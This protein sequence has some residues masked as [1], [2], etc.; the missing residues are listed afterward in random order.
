[1]SRLYFSTE[2]ETVEVKGWERHWL[3]AL[4]DNVALGVLDPRNR[5]GDL[6]ALI[7][8]RHYL[9]RSQ[10][11]SRDQW[12]AT[13]SVALR[14]DMSGDSTAPHSTPL[15]VWRGRPLSGWGLV[16][17][18]AAVVGNDAIKLAARLH[19]Q[20]E[21]HAWIDGPD[22]AWVADMIE[23]AVISGVYRSRLK[24]SDHQMPDRV[25]TS[26]SGWGELITFLRSASDEPVVTHYS[27]TDE[28]PNPAVAGFQ[29]GWEAWEDLPADEQWRRGM[30]G[31]RSGTWSRR[32]TGLQI[33]PDDWHTFRFHHT[34]TAFDLFA[35][36][37]DER[38]DRALG[39]TA[40][41]AAK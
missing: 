26:Y 1:M 36:D 33:K 6:E 34:L 3:G 13:F 17:N 7:N 21:L 12:A 22:R 24:S 11:E 16:L 25:I 31:L 9:S 4:V 35:P 23:Q 41:E 30:E 15:L 5:A 10:G 19:A 28:F 37:R 14:N 29:A 2:D 39:I 27:I 8:P 18:T 20:S 40:K 38:L 32:F